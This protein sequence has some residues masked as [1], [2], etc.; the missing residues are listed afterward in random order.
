[1]VLTELAE[2]VTEADVAAATEAEY[3]VAAGGPIP[4]LQ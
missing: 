1:M 4:M 3:E 2:G